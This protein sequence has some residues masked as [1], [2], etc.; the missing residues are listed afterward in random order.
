MS[1]RP[2]SWWDW[3]QFRDSLATTVARN[4]VAKNMAGNQRVDRRLDRK[5]VRTAV[6]WSVVEGPLLLM[7]A[8]SEGKEK[9]R[10][11][12]LQGQKYL[13]HKK[14]PYSL[15]SSFHH[16]RFNDNFTKTDW[17]IWTWGM[18]VDEWPMCSISRWGSRQRETWRKVGPHYIY[19]MCQ[20]WIPHFKGVQSFTS[21]LKEVLLT[22]CVLHVFLMRCNPH[23]S[24]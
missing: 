3:F 15:D 20:Y 23:G 24:H 21:S 13:A 22:D 10:V 6:D 1:S 9:T 14:S 7:T 16:S 8:R 5:V 17:S 4:S 18:T 11:K 12:T 19:I 2:N